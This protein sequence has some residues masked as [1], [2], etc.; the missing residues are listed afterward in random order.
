[1][2]T[3]HVGDESSPHY[4]RAV[5]ELS[6]PSSTTAGDSSE[7]HK[8]ARLEGDFE[9]YRDSSEQCWSPEEDWGLDS[10]DDMA[11]ATVP[12]PAAPQ[13]RSTCTTVQSS[14]LLTGSLGHHSSLSV[15]S[16]RTEASES[17]LDDS[18][19]RSVSLPEVVVV[20]Q[21][22]TM[23]VQGQLDALTTRMETWSITNLRALRKQN[24]LVDDWRQRQ[25]QVKKAKRD[26]MRA[27][28]ARAPSSVSSG[29]ADL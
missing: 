19:R 26:V 15:S 7:P 27:L 5:G 28:K 11:Q 18:R 20:E 22:D 14:W 25:L 9:S 8:R 21:D 12:P 10:S 3:G 17:E 13:R 24:W 4:K 1:M 16:T 6:P 2:F 29:H 23:Q